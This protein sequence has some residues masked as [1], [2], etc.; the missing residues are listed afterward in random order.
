MTEYSPK[1]IK[2]SITGNGSA[3]KEQVS[4]MLHNLLKFD[5]SEGY[6]DATDA[7]GAAV[8]HYFQNK[9]T[10][11]I[12]KKNYKGWSSFLNDNPNRKI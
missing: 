3:S 1:K 5:N 12:E 10:K 11:G 9:N 7:L 2:M 6:L 4:A 8:C